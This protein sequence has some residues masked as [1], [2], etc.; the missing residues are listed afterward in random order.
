M[1][2]AITYLALPGEMVKYGPVF[3]LGKVAAYPFVAVVVGW[4]I[5]PQIMKLRIT[6]AYEV[7]ESRLGLSVRMLGSTFFLL[8]RLMWMGVI[9][10]ATSSK[11][12]VPLL[13][14]EQSATPYFCAVLALI[15]VAYTSLGGLRAVVLTDVIQTF[16]LFGG[17]LLT[18]GLITYH[19][20]GFGGWWPTSW[21]VHW[22]EPTW[23]Y[24]A[25]PDVR[26]FTAALLAT[27]FWYVCTQGSDQ[28]AVQRFLAT[29]DVKAAR[30]TLLWA[31][32]TSA[33]A[34][35]LLT[36]VG[37]AVFAFFGAN[38]HLLPDGG[39]IVSDADAL[40]PRFIAFGLPPGFSGLVMAG[41]LA[42][43]MSSLSSGV[44]SACSVVVVD[45]IDRFGTR[46]GGKGSQVR[47]A[48]LVSVF[49][50]VVVVLLSLLVGGVQGNLLA[51]AFKVCNLLT[52]PLFGLFFLALFVPWATEWGTLVGAACGLVVVV[53]ISFW[54]EIFGTTPM[55][56]FLWSMPLSLATQVGVGMLASLLPIG[57][58][59]GRAE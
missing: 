30:R 46:A 7:L 10:Y 39:R 43:A 41:L 57:R 37:L 15:T 20:G 18:L 29:R 50:G 48:V 21:P 1:L 55:I 53:A 28:M 45:F 40:F 11:V 2:S 8:L 9:V 4:F 34:T 27:F 49:V 17:A 22:P 26:T 33:L 16:I 14:F 3:A 51:I 56:S 59:P 52:A 44:N 19:L 47:L 32:V 58:K 31:L 6:S 54:E 23:G 13:G 35:L 38:P 12:L 5:I 42:A 24:D 25:D 36:I